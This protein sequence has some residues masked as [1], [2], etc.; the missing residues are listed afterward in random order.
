MKILVLGGG[1][2]PEREVSLRS[3]A[4]VA[5]AA[6][7]AGFEV[8]EA[9]PKYEPEILNTLPIDA[10]VFPILHG[11]G[12]EDGVI[13]K[14]LE[15]L[16]LA[17]LGSGSQVSQECF[18]KWTTRQKLEAAG[19]VMP[20]A[21]LVTKDTYK[22][23]DLIKTPYVLKV[24][25][26]GSSIG[27][28]VVHDPSVVDPAKVEELFGL[29]DHAVLEELIEGDEVTVPVLDSSA[30][31]VIEII[32][33][34]NEEF[35]YDNKYNGRTQ[36]LCPA[37]N[38]SADLQKQARDMAERVHYVMGARHLS[39]VDMMIDKDDRIYVLEIN[40]MPGMTTG[41]LYPKSAK[42]A[43]MDMPALVKKFAE[44]VTKS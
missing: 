40:T 5:T 13:Q 8:L 18:D 10:L 6:R 32:P 21:R 42:E 36:E 30:L 38:I 7:A 35:D 27:T 20:K 15:D 9:D 2:S 4:N 12:G 11:A 37:K 43:G 19:I 16:K 28:L 39:R 26:G 3:A 33:P 34:A 14:Q 29:D 22:N 23:T 31:P 1:E 17:F 44:L 25:R 24:A 41:S